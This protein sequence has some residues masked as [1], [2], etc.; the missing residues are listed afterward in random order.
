MCRDALLHRSHEIQP[1]FFD[2]EI[3]KLNCFLFLFFFAKSGTSLCLV[4]AGYGFVGFDLAKK[5]KNLFVVRKVHCSTATIPL[6]RR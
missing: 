1:A 3:K 6:I 5:M 4:T 2:S